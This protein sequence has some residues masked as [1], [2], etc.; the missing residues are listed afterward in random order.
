MFCQVT[1]TAIEKKTNTNFNNAVNKVEKLG[2]INMA[3][4]N[5]AYKTQP[6]F[7]VIQ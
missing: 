7:I 6:I 4:I 2:N 5:I 3:I 1:D